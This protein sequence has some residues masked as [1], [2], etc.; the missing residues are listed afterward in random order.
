VSARQ[1]LAEREAQRERYR[2]KAIAEAALM[3][4]TIRCRDL[5]TDLA[6]PAHR[7]CHGEAK[8]GAGCLCRCHDAT[9]GTEVLS[10][11]D[12]PA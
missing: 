7:M 9:A 3:G 6:D 8:R 5:Q 2:D 1:S 11:H 10:K 12:V 4:L